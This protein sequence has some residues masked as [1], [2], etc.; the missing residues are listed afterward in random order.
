ME[1]I[2]IW[3]ADICSAG[4]EITMGPEGSLPSSNEYTTRFYVEPL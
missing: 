2:S 3:E 4:Q 1:D